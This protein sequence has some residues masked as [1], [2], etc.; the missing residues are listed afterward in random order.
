MPN[1]YSLRLEEKRNTERQYFWV[2]LEW[3]LV[4]DV[5]DVGRTLFACLPHRKR[6]P[7]MIAAAFLAVYGEDIK[8]LDECPTNLSKHGASR[9]RRSPRNTVWRIAQPHMRKKWQN[10]YADN[11]YELMN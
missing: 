6:S 3:A 4:R 7:T 9:H 1:S 2:T 10:F 8:M 11:L 5:P